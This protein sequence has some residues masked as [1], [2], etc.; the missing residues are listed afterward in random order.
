[1]VFVF[2][3]SSS[4]DGHIGHYVVERDQ[5]ICIYANCQTS[6]FELTESYHYSYDFDAATSHTA[7]SW[8]NLALIVVCNFFL[9]GKLEN[10]HVL[11]NF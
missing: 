5:N 2:S 6:L 4:F 11:F 1:M 7:D 8:K 10:V 9:L 3:I